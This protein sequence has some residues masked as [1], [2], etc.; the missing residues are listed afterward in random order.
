MK[1]QGLGLRVGVEGSGFRREWGS[2]WK[3]IYGDM[4][5]CVRTYLSLHIYVYIFMYILQYRLKCKG[6]LY[7]RVTYACMYVCMYGQGRVGYGMYVCMYD[8]RLPPPSTFTW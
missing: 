6:L 7:G 2:E 8:R 5:V 3:Y 4:C 1:V